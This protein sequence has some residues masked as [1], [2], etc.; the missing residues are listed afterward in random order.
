MIR[1]QQRLASKPKKNGAK[2]SSFLRA[3]DI[4]AHENH[5]GEPAR[6]RRHRGQLHCGYHHEALCKDGTQQNADRVPLVGRDRDRRRYNLR[7]LS[8]PLRSLFPRFPYFFPSPPRRAIVSE[9]WSQN[10]SQHQTSA[11]K[12]GFHGSRRYSQ[13]CQCFRNGQLMYIAQHECLPIVLRQRGE[14]LD[15]SFA[16]FRELQSCR[17]NLAPVF[18]I[19]GTYGFASSLSSVSDSFGIR[20]CFRFLIRASLL[21]I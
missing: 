4:G 13:N 2:F 16:Y 19:L 11:P 9:S 18:E 12:P 8:R 10:V 17:R 3:S 7:Y 15:Q 20:H 14:G 6:V 5:L 21:A 1:P